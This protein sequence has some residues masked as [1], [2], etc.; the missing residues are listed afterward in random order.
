M[1]EYRV[2]IREYLVDNQSYHTHMDFTK[3]FISRD[4]LKQSILKRLGNVQAYSQSSGRELAKIKP[5]IKGTDN[6]DV[7]VKE[8]NKLRRWDI[9]IKIYNYREGKL[10]G[11]RKI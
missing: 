10:D 2:I 5:I 1:V 4:E 11:Y 7:M 3:E 6:L 8:I 9:A